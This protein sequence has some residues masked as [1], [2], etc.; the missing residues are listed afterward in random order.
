[1][2][3]MGFEGFLHFEILKTHEKFAHDCWID[4]VHM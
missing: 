1:M 3:N 4:L 2:R